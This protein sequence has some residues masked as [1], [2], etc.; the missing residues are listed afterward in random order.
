MAKSQDPIEKLLD[1]IDFSSLSPEEI[2]GKDGLLKQLTKRM[3]EKAMN[4][5]MDSHLGY[6][7]YHRTK[8]SSNSRNG[9]SKKIVSTEIVV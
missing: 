2:T 4:A 5:E 3:L 8:N 9:N 6:E 1:E 7:K